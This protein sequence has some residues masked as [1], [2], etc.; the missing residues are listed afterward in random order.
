[1][2]TLNLEESAAPVW[3]ALN[4]VQDRTARMEQICE[5]KA[6]AV[7]RLVAKPDADSVS[8]LEILVDALSK[9]TQEL[10][11]LVDKYACERLAW[12][13]RLITHPDVSKEAKATIWLRFQYEV[14]L[15][16]RLTA[17]DVLDVFIVLC[18]PHQKVPVTCT[19]V[20]NAVF[21]RRRAERRAGWRHS[22]RHIPL[23]RIE[24]KI[25]PSF[26]GKVQLEHDVQVLFRDVQVPPKLQNLIIARLAGKV[27][28]AE[29]GWSAEEFY[30][31]NRAIAADRQCGGKLRRWVRTYLGP[32]FCAE[33]KGGCELIPHSINQRRK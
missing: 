24:L 22:H 8:A 10:G 30:V 28:R 3:A 15:G 6:A 21:E 29:Q 1:M 16:P 9:Y 7:T 4:A 5:V 2:A 18:K 17:A 19:Y 13:S 12:Y 23:D 31:L 32:N 27:D 14:T 25:A 11:I 26:A 20:R 33:E